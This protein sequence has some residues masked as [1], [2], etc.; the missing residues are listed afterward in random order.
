MWF[1][2]EPPPLE[3]CDVNMSSHI[4]IDETGFYLKC[5]SKKYG[6]GHTTVRV[7]HPDHYSRKEIK[8]NIILA[9]GPEN[10]NLDPGSVGSM[11]H[12]R[13]WVFITQRNVD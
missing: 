1:K 11:M 3:I 2:S 9:V 4:D 6:R 13:R 7:R 5:V 8:W 12:P 10:P